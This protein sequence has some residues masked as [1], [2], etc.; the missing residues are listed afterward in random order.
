LSGR[1]LSLGNAAIRLAYGV[2]VLLSPFRPVSGTLQLAPDTDG[3]PEARLF[4]RGFAAHQLG[5]GALG[6]LGAGN[7]DLRRSAML[8]AAATDASDFASAAIEAKSRGRVDPDLS[9]GMLFSSAGLLSAVLAL[10]ADS[11]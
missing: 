4:V 5:A 6:L 1:A 9:G 11:G 3:H 7:R 8:L 2:A 10:R